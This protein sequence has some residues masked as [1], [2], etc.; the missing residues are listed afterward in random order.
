MN[1]HYEKLNYHFLKYNTYELIGT[2]YL[3]FIKLSSQSRMW[4]TV[5]KLVCETN[6]PTLE[7]IFRLIHLYVDRR[8][9]FFFCFFLSGHH[10]DC[11]PRLHSPLV[12]T[13]E[14]VLP[15]KSMAYQ[16]F[17][18]STFTHDVCAKPWNGFQTLP[19]S[20]G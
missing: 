3:L 19:N 16:P 20:T 11:Q 1:V 17:R 12:R 13:C 6:S 9:V 2:F 10:L 15:R 7:A 14:F 8:W 5:G 18:L 4:N